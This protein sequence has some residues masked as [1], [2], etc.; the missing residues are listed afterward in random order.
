MVKNQALASLASASLRKKCGAIIPIYLYCYLRSTREREYPPL[1][2]YGSLH[3]LQDSPFM[4]IPKFTLSY[5][6]DQLL[7]SFNTFVYLLRDTILLHLQVS[8]LGALVPDRLQLRDDPLSVPGNPLSG[9]NEL[10][11]ELFQSIV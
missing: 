1:S 2:S 4:V 8:C 5:S 11:L 10:L 6:S 9:F 7:H 3:E